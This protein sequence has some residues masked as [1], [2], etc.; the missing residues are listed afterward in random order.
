MTISQQEAILDKQ[1]IRIQKLLISDEKQSV[2]IQHLKNENKVRL[3][4]IVNKNCNQKKVDL[5]IIIH[6]IC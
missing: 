6:G 5:S 4:Y 1:S 2:F 3:H